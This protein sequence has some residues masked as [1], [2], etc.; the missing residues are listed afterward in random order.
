MAVEYHRIIPRRQSGT[1]FPPKQGNDAARSSLG[2]MYEAGR[3]VPQD[4]VQ[5]HVWFNLA[6]SQN[7][8][9]VG[10]AAGLPNSLESAFQE[11]AIKARDRVASKMT[12]EQI[13]EAQRLAREWKPK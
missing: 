3:N 10:S 11:A 4:Y 2:L 5:A 12:P 1:G 6:A 9:G 13:A 7:S 8:F